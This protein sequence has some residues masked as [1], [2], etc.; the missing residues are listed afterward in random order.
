MGEREG[1]I[2]VWLARACPL[3]GICPATQAQTDVPW[4]GIEPTSPWFTGWRSIHWARPAGLDLEGIMLTEMSQSEKE[5]YM[6]H[7]HVECKEQNKWT[8]KIETDS[9][10]QGTNSC[11]PEG[12]G[13]EELGEKGEGIKKYKLVVKK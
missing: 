7:S 9:S 4:L 10:M 3:L 12:R 6:F 2:N 13:V 8:N 1:N 5:K 11:L